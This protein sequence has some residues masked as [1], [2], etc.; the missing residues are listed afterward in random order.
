M[1]STA[2][3][4]TQSLGAQAKQL[5]GMSGIFI[6]VGEV[7]GGSLFGILGS[8]TIRWGRSPIVVSG[9]VVHV[10]AFFLIF[11]NIPNEAPIKDTP[12]E[13]FITTNAVLAIFC[14]FLLGFADSCYNTQ[15][16]ST[17]GGVFSYD[18]ASAFAI[19]KFTQV[20]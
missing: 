12:D 18:S 4:A 5:V 9:F 19:F 2:I 8:K 10:V 15:I 17:L 1:Y 14:S 11:L 16:Y 13:A 3:G 6:G 20:T 7:L